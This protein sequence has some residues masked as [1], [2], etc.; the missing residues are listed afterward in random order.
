MVNR[1][2]A[3]RRLRHNDSY[4]PNGEGGKRPDRAVIV[5]AQRCREAYRDV[6]IVIGGIEA[7]LRRIAHYDYWSDKVRRSVLVD[8]KAD[9]LVYGNAERAIVEVAHRARQG[10]STVRDARR[11]PRR[12]PAADRRA[13][14]LD[15]SCAPTIID[16]AATRAPRRSQPTATPSS[17]LPAFEQVE[18]RPGGSMPTPRACCIGR[19]IPAMRGALVQRHG[20]RELWLNPPP[21]PLTTR[22]DGRGLRPALCARA[23]SLLWRGQDPRLGD[24]PLL[25]HHHARLL[26]RLLL[27]LDH[28]A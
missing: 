20:D 26:R 28:R 1:Y 14:R 23:A 13:R 27:L 11:R 6:P 3:D 22:G 25:G 7:S 18:R 24:D 10:R 15:R 16:D 4:T 5:Y 19:A 21:I 12:R 8:A 2:T 9:I 17:A